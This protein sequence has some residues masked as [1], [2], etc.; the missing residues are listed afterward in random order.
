MRYLKIGIAWTIS[1]T[2]LMLPWRLRI[3]FSELLGWV[4]QLVPPDLY[5]MEAMGPDEQGPDTPPANPG[6]IPAP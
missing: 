4:A 3:L 2:G 5:T 1:V 6:E